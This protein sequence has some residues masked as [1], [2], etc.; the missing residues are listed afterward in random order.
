[1]DE[2]PNKLLG[3]WETGIPDLGR[4]TVLCLMVKLYKFIRIYQ[5]HHLIWNK[6]IILH[7]IP[8]STCGI[9]A[10]IGACKLLPHLGESRVQGKGGREHS[11]PLLLNM[12]PQAG[13][14]WTASHGKAQKESV[15]WKLNLEAHG[16]APS[17]CHLPEK[18]KL[19]LCPTSLYF[20]NQK[21]T[22]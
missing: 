3:G 7:Q 15:E 6:T 20:K 9:G 18:T 19:S 12:L 14:W 1:M 13:T 21:C 5:I 11:V 2:M 10:P 16:A 22:E 8:S 17:A 4:I